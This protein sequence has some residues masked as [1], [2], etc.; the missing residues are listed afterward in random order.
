MKIGII[1]KGTV[2]TAVW[3]GLRQIGHDL[4]S[5][6]IRDAN[7]SMASVCL[8]EIIFVCV[9]TNS[10]DTGACDISQVSKVMQELDAM[11]YT[12][13]VA[14]KSTVLPGTTQSLIS[15]Y[16]DLTLAFVP[17]FLRAKSALNDFMD[18][19]DVLIVGCHDQL[20]YDKI[21]A[22]HGPIPHHSIRV[23]PDEAEM[24]KYFSNLYNA[25]RI[26][27]ANSMFEMCQALDIDYQPVL[28]AVTNRSQI[29]QEYLRC[30]ATFRGFGGHCL[31]KDAAAFDRL[32]QDL[33]LDHVTLFRSMIEDNIQHNLRQTP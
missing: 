30:S 23:T 18:Q 31:P 6:D 1:G 26:T 32:R 8:A 14:V 17:E 24:T 4:T 2:G 9:P 33:G 5:Y 27:F 29:G 10:M 16:P 11:R 3:D 7:S 13:I 21:V 20:V 22:S 28:A 19:H 25:M 15:R 12:G